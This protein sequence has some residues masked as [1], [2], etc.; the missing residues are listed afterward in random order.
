VVSH[1]S[2]CKDDAL[3]LAF[4]RKIE[5]P[6]LDNFLRFRLSQIVVMWREQAIPL[7]GYMCYP[8]DPEARDALWLTLLRWQDTS[9]DGPP[10][11]P[12]KLGRIQHNWLRVADIV[13]AHSDLIAGQHQAR[14]GGASI[15]KAITLVEANAKSSGTGA[16]TRLRA[17]RSR[18]LST[19]CSR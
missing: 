12:E 10:T 16:S 9:N 6:D 14:R 19:S 4:P 18:T 8:N 11:I 5:I 7:L 2:L 15:G 1:C 17:C 3:G 13:N